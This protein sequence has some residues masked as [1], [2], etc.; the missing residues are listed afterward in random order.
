MKLENAK[1]KKSR[2]N[3][4]VLILLSMNRVYPKKRLTGLSLLKL[5]SE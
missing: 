3:G 4:Y 2:I 1:L 5:N